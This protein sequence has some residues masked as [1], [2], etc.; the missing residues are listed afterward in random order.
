MLDLETT[1]SA[2]SFAYGMAQNL[3]SSLIVEWK[4]RKED[5]KAQEAAEL[6]ERHE[7]SKSFEARVTQT[8]CQAFCNLNLS[9]AQFDILVPSASDPVFGTELARQIIEDRYTSESVAALIARCSPPAEDA[10]IQKLRRTW[11][12]N[13]EALAA[14]GSYRRQQG[15]LDEAV[16]LFSEA[17]AYA[18]GP[19]RDFIALELADVFYSRDQ[20]AKAAELYESVVDTTTVNELSKRYLVCLYNAGPHKEALRLAQTLR[21]SG[22]PLPVISQIEANILS[23]IGD[24][25][26]AFQIMVRLAELHPQAHKYKIAGA[27]FA[28]R[29]GQQAAAKKMLAEVKFEDI[30]ENAQ[31]LARVGQLRAVLGMGEVLRHL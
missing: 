3:V 28:L 23:E 30:R 8:T 25:K 6:F 18:A 15:E 10:V 29:R 21:G 12:R 26:S 13:S 17:L 24:L 1:Q 9:K 14:V 19:T 16:G 27:E 22:D 31:A 20:F 7:H 4:K 2:Q 11:P 5:R